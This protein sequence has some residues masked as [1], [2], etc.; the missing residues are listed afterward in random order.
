VKLPECIEEMKSLAWL[1]VSGCYLDC[2][3]QGV[4]RLEFFY[5]L[6]LTNNKRL[7]EATR[8]HRK[9]EIIDMA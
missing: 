8:M 2:L 1:D 9:N 7:M 5:K 3:P 6:M 4:V